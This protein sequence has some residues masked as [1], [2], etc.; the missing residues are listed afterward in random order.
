MGITKLRYDF[1][2]EN[3]AIRKC[4]LQALQNKHPGCSIA[5]DGVA[6]LGDVANLNHQALSIDFVQN[7]F[8][9]VDDGDIG[10]NPVC[11][12]YRCNNVERVFNCVIKGH[13]PGAFVGNL[14]PDTLALAG[15]ELGKPYHDSFIAREF[16]Y[17]SDGEYHFYPLMQ[18]EAPSCVYIPSYYGRYFDY[19]TQRNYVV[20]ELLQSITHLNQ[21]QRA[22]SWED[23]YYEAVIDGLAYLHAVFLNRDS[24][25]T[26]NHDWLVGPFLAAAFE[27]DR[28]IWQQLFQRM[29]EYFPDWVPKCN[30]DIQHSWINGISDWWQQAYEHCPKTIVHGDFNPRNLGFTLKANG[31]PQLMALDWECIRWGLPQLDF[32]QFILHSSAPDRVVD[33]MQYYSERMRQRLCFYSGMQLDPR[34]WQQGLD[35]AVAYHLINRGPLLALM[36]K[37]FMP[38]TSNIGLWMYRNAALVL[39]GKCPSY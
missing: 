12:R 24:D 14:C 15:I 7:K 18:Q 2:M 23:D 26:L 13:E 8:D 20:I 36:A 19:N 3:V 16:K 34:S 11:V 4:L 30:H 39:Q 9:V 25:P 31:Q 37:F 6:K 21:W 33:R 38:N 29:A 28:S 32:A 17:L 1:S 5:L 22:D 27:G 10:F 35:A